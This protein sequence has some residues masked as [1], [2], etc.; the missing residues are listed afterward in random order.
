MNLLTLGD[1]KQSELP[2]QLDLCPDDPRFIRRLNRAI[3]WVM[4]CG[5]FNGT[6]R[7]VRF[8]V[9][10]SCFVTPGWC[11]NVESIRACGG[12]KRI[13]SNW[14]TMLPGWHPHSG[15][16]HGEV[17]HGM[18][19]WF[20]FHDYVCS[21]RQ[22]CGPRILRVFPTS[23][24]DVGK[25]I[26][27]LGQDKNKI[28]VRT[29][30]GG[31]I[32]DGEVVTLALP[33]SDTLT[34]WTSVPAIVKDETDDAVRV[35][36]LVAGGA[37]LTG[38]G[39]YEY[40]ETKPTYQRY[41]VMNRREMRAPGCC[42]HDAIEAEVKLAFVPVKNDDDILAITNRPALEMA[43]MGVKAL[44]DGDIARADVLLYGSPNNQ[45]V[46]AIPLLNN[47]IRTNTGDRFAANVRIGGPCGFK[48]LMKGF[49]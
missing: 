4:T 47:E 26:K 35:F 40:W 25:K 20:Q 31:V 37:T 39:L 7:N 24:T 1:M 48:T 34:E 19:L 49:I 3:E 12:A 27:F 6:T 42:D 45:R 18:D 14:Y 44:D 17:W 41:R 32:M 22:L 2:A 11:A 21:F 29:N 16:K 28:W 46:G 36:S 15:H 9:D 13:E 38:F 30:Q 8:C 10:S 5:S 43:V 23:K 33:F